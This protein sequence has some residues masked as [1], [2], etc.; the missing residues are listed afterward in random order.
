MRE[1]NKIGKRW[2]NIMNKE[3]DLNWSVDEITGNMTDISSMRS[4]EFQVKETSNTELLK[5]YLKRLGN[6]E[7]VQDMQFAKEHFTSI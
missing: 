1:P 4:K 5:D 6:G 3:M 2:Y 7:V